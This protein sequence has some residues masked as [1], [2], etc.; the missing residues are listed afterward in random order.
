[1]AKSRSLGS[2]SID[3]RDSKICIKCYYPLRGLRE[4]ICPECGR[5]FDPSNTKSFATPR[6][7]LHRR[8]ALTW[9]ISFMLFT[10]IA[11]FF[12]FISAGFGHG[13]YVVAGMLFPYS[14]AVMRMHS[15]PQLVMALTV[16][17][18]P[19]YGFIQAIAQ[20]KGRPWISI[21]LIV[22]SH[23][24]FPTILWLIRGG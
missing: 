19:A 15:Y 10:P 22:I 5:H 4:P 18:F 24:G 6:R 14:L 21:S 12:A 16:I 20:I 7:R 1:M 23:F 13:D 9:L 17:Q 3:E 8:W 11:W 2:Y